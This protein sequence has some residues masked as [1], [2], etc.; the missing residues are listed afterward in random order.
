M[1]LRSGASAWAFSPSTYKVRFSASA[2][3]RTTTA[4]RCVSRDSRPMS[5]AAL[6]SQ[7]RR[8]AVSLHGPWLRRL[9]V[10]GRRIAPRAGGAGPLVSRLIFRKL[11]T[12]ARTA[13]M[14]PANT[15]RR[16]HES[17]NPGLAPGGLPRRAA[18]RR[19]GPGERRRA[20]RGP[21]SDRDSA[22]APQP[23]GG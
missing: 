19:P 9:A 20:G 22:A 21:S 5:V 4:I 8:E 15:S 11:G 13:G 14:A 16:C 18:P 3:Y 2:R 1:G 7:R 10:S 23:L 6:R 12:S 17:G